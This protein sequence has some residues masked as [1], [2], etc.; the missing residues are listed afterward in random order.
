[1]GHV[2]VL[3]TGFLKVSITIWFDFD[4]VDK[5]HTDS[6]IHVCVHYRIL[7]SEPNVWFLHLTYQMIFNRQEIIKPIIIYT[8]PW[9]KLFL[10]RRRRLF[11]IIIKKQF[12]SHTLNLEERSN[13]RILRIKKAY[14]YVRWI[15]GGD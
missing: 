11:T 1:M 6:H 5:L 7:M 14:Y 15:F 2:C 3:F 10:Q 13:H 9:L 12:Y 4:T 8:S